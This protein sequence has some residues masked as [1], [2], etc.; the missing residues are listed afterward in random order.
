[1]TILEAAAALRAQ[2]ISSVELTEDSLKRIADANPKLNA[3]ITVLDDSARKQ[4]AAMDAEL[5]SGIDR[6]PLQGIPF[7]HKDLVQTKGVLTTAGSKIFAN[8]VPDEDA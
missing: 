8:F 7:A 2:R 1:M 4:A 5:A 6:G 3:F